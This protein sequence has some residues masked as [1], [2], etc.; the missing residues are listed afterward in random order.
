MST[1]LAIGRRLL[2]KTTLAYSMARKCEFRIILDP[3]DQIQSDGYRVRE[4]AMLDQALDLMTIEEPAFNELL[5]TPDR[6][7]QGM[8]DATCAHVRQ[9][10]KEFHGQPKRRLAF[11][12]D[13]ARF[14]S[15]MDSDAFEWILRAAPPNEVHL[16]LTAHQPKDFPTAIR[17][18][19]D[20][21]MVFR[22]TQET[23]LAVVRERCGIEVAEA[24]KQLK[25][26]QFID[27]NDATGEARAY[28]DPA[29]WFVPLRAG[30][31]ETS[32][33]LPEPPENSKV[34]GNKLF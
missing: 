14:Y 26:H 20:R 16:I 2:G 25:P 8:F 10:A 27:W 13:E 32:E 21:W 4:D 22:M 3:R 11:I 34:D 15:L 30:S 19:A 33:I 24:V 9:W 31:G 18:I 28:R 6:N 5:V 1:N 17:A 12:V 7:V 23:D 29:A